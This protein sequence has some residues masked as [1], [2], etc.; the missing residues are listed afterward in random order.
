MKVEK[1]IELVWIY[2]KIG[3]QCIIR[4]ILEIEVTRKGKKEVNVV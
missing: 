4:K 2:E 3:V 1:K